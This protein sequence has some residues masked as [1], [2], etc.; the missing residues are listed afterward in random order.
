MDSPL[1]K[2]VGGATSRGCCLL[3]FKDRGGLDAI[4]HRLQKRYRLDVIPGTNEFLVQLATE[5]NRYFE[6]SLK[7]FTVTLDL[8]G[9]SFQMAVWEQ[10]LRIPYGET[11]TYGEIARLIGNPRAVRAVGQANGENSVAIV[12]PCHRVIQSDGSLRGYGGGMW[13]KKRLLAL[14]SGYSEVAQPNMWGSESLE[15]GHQAHST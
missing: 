12:V 6:G 10:L 4:K 14:E 1:G 3:E 5:L 2:M 8:K 15:N 9:S 7:D 11:R 13:R